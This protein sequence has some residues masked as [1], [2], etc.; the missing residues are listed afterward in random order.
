MGVGKTTMVES[1]IQIA[2]YRKWWA[3]L[4]ASVIVPPVGLVLLWMR[5]W[6]GWKSVVL[7]PLGTLGIAIL[8]LIHLFQF[9]GLR[10]E[11]SGAGYIPILTFHDP[12]KDVEQLEKQRAAQRAQA[13]PAAAAPQQAEANNQL[14][15]TTKSAATL[16]SAAEKSGDEA[17][18]AA[19]PMVRAYWTDYRGPLRDGNYAEQAVLAAWPSGGLKPLWKQPVGGGYASFVVA[20]GLAF[21]IEQRRGNEVTAAYELLTGREMWTNSWPAEFR[22]SMGGDGPR[23]TP[24]WSDGRLYAL[25]AEGELRCLEAATGK[26]IWRT[27]ILQENGASNIMWGMASSPLVVDGKVIV[28]PGGPNAA[29]VAYDALS[30]KPVWKSLSDQA[31]YTAP[32]VATLA[33]QRQLLIVMA[34]RASGLTIE[35][36]KLLWEYPWQ[37]EYDVNAAQPILVDANRFFISAGYGHGAAVLEIARDGAG[38]RAKEIWKNTEMKNRFSSSVLYE[39]K[40]YGF[41][42]GIFACVDVK[43]GQ[44]CWKGGRYGYGQVLLAG[45]NLI[46]LSELGDLVLLRAT[47]EKL[48]ELSRFSAIDGKTWNVPAIAEGILLVRNTREMAAFRISP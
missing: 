42:E 9:Y 7:R 41:D 6:R 30:G 24:T 2:W 26:T 46:V 45:G 25:G 47:P 15:P 44:R 16:K 33:G 12:R 35:D 27:N 43:T 13:P 10:A 23:A 39:G 4:L 29:V 48:D 37:T 22:E 20:G 8:G 31:A 40:I 3:V 14:Q 17:K 11:M 19:Q 34:K 18:D 38:F 28:L 1:G 32:M 5:P 36:G 21:T